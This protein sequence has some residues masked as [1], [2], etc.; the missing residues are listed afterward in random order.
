M[1]TNMTHKILVA[2]SK[3]A[4]KRG[5]FTFIWNDGDWSLYIFNYGDSIW[6]DRDTKI[7]EIE[8]WMKEQED[9]S[10]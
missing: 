6:I 4:D 10:Q 9:K 3:E 7:G 1:K 8:D 2:V 5:Y